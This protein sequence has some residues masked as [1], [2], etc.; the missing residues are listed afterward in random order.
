MCW[1]F[2]M[3]ESQSS[4][5]IWALQLEIVRTDNSQAFSQ[6]SVLESYLS[7]P[8][9]LCY[10][11]T[12]FP[13]FL[14]RYFVSKTDKAVVTPLRHFQGITSTLSLSVSLLHI[15]GLEK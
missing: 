6:L 8:E 11:H 13:L 1:C 4:H 2:C 3:G 12:Y 14:V 5:T 10:L 7:D 9:K 15:T